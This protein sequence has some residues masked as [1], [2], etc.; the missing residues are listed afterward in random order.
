MT[1]CTPVFGLTYPAPTDSPCTLSDTW[2][3][4]AGEV[5]DQLDA[6]DEII[7]RTAT[8][9]PMAFLSTSSI[10]ITPNTSSTTEAFV[11][12]DT[13]Q[14]D[15]DNMTNLAVYP[16][17][18]TINTPGVYL[19]LAVVELRVVNAAPT[20]ARI[21]S[22]TFLNGVQTNNN[23][24]LFSNYPALTLMPIQNDR[25]RL[26]NVAGTIGQI[27]NMSTG[28]QATATYYAQTGSTSGELLYVTSKLGVVWLRDPL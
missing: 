24:M 22:Q 14:V 13:V 21:S 17:G 8:S 26:P 5:D 15:T 9:V 23:W 27:S 2:C 28:E 11:T 12:Y 6:I 25:N 19:R 16:N 18:I 4:F 10:F 1:S 3:E 20:Y 7:A